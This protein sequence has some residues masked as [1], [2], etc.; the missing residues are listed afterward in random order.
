MMNKSRGISL[1]KN[2]KFEAYVCARSNGKQAGSNKNF[3]KLYVGTYP[4]KEEA[5]IAR[6][7]YI[8]SLI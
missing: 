5:I 2:G 6:T 4:T 1:K 3:V 7:S 8:R